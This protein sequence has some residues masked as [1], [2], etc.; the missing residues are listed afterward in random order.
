MTALHVLCEAGRWHALKL[1]VARGSNPLAVF[2]GDDLVTL[3]VNNTKCPRR[4]LAECIKLGVCTFHRDRVT[5]LGVVT[6]E[7][8]PFLA[9]VD[10]GDV[11]LMRM[12]YESGACS[13]SQLQVHLQ[14]RVL[15]RS[16]DQRRQDVQRWQGRDEEDR[17][18]RKDALRYLATL[19]CTPRSLASS[20]RLVISHTLGAND[21]RLRAASTLPLPQ[22]LQA[23][24]LFSDL[25][26][27]SMET[28]NSDDVETENSDDVE[29]ETENS[30][31]VETENR[32]DFETENREDMETENREDFET[33]NSDD[34]ETE[35]IDDV[36]T[37]NRED[38]ETENREDV[39]TDNESDKAE[40]SSSDGLSLSDA[41]ANTTF[42]DVEATLENMCRDLQ[43]EED[44]DEETVDKDSETVGYAVYEAEEEEEEEEEMY[45]DPTE[46]SDYFNPAAAARHTVT[47]PARRHAAA[48]SH[49][50]G[51]PFTTGT[52]HIAPQSSSPPTSRQALSLASQAEEVY[53]D[54]DDDV[55]GPVIQAAS[56]SRLP[57]LPPIPSQSSRRS[58][59][60]SSQTLRPPPRPPRGIP[61]PSPAPHNNE[62]VNVL[63]MRGQPTSALSTP[64]GHTASDVPSVPRGR[65]APPPPPPPARNSADRE[66]SRPPPDEE[67]YYAPHAV[68]SLAR[69]GGD[70]RPPRPPRCQPASSQPRSPAG[71]VP[72]VSGSGTYASS[73]RL[74][75]P[76]HAATTRHHNSSSANH[77]SSRTTTN[78]HD[79]EEEEEQEEDD[80][81]DIYEEADEEEEIYEE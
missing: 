81:E 38:F 60:E 33:E 40:P 10:Q 76:S 74:S 54:F 22:H 58:R 70:A 61:V 12:L 79:E 44:D 72:R 51:R 34:V 30:D 65:R 57:P 31:D 5:S 2:K 62:S 69:L 26:S 55:Y 6:Y 19:A 8:S 39:E 53:D 75:Q 59:T 35:N 7:Q 67:E 32:E 23:Y 73:S 48:A 11:L 17:T 29:T 14:R 4:L 71:G 78:T 1:C 49:N 43:Q 21:L 42:P 37:E 28:E 15:K 80:Y 68:T 13:N 56:R 41:V 66:R 24:V 27:L 50:P 63:S 18:R 9:D 77:A 64:S 45:P 47:G 36:E 52:T 3:A 46:L 25:T 20:C 16:A